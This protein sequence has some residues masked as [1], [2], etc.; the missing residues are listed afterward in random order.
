[1][2]YSKQPIILIVDD[3]LTILKVLSGAMADSGW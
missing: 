2:T 3:N 1:M